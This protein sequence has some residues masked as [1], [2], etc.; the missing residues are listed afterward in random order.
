MSA[1]EVDSRSVPPGQPRTGM[2]VVGSDI[3]EVGRVKE[4]RGED[5]LVDRPLHRDVYVPHTV[6]RNVTSHR[7][8]L[9]V[10]A[11]QVD[12]MGWHKP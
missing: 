10:P 6:V 2:E 8:V 5:F 1:G 3:V 12:R 7:V 11:A 9:A 4:V